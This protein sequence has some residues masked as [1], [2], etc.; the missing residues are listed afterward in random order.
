MNIGKLGVFGDSFACIYTKWDMPVYAIDTAHRGLSWL[1][2]VEDQY[3]CQVANYARPGSAFNF[4]LERYLKERYMFDYCIFVVSSP[5]RVYAKNTTIACVNYHYLLEMI[6]KLK[7]LD[8]TD[9][10]ISDLEILNSVVVY[11]EKWMNMDLVQNI[12]HSVVNFILKNHPNTL[13]IPAFADSCDFSSVGLTDIAHYELQ[14]I[15]SRYSQQVAIKHDYR[16]CHF[17]KENNRIIFDKVRDA[18]DNGKQ[19]LNLDLNDTLKPSKE[20]DF[21]IDML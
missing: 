20:L 5:F 19:F 10:V 15:D 18:I 4:S 13:I 21:Y 9:E 16:K 17:S 1:E 2:L 14:L 8:Q 11:L 6:A 7:G 12:Q 3:Q